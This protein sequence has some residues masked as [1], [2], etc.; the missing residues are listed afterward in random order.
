MPNIRHI[1]SS[2]LLLLIITSSAAQIQPK[3]GYLSYNSIFQAMPE[4]ATAQQKLKELKSK[5]DAEA[6]R[7]ENDFQRKFNEFLQGQKDFPENILQK[8]Q[9]EL[10][11]L[12]EEGIRFRQEA[13]EL[14]KKAEKELQADMLFILNEAIKAVGIE[15]NY[16]FIINI[17]G[18]TCPFINPAN[19]D[20]V[21]NKVREKLNLPLVSLPQQTTNQTVK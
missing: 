9:N 2:V 7:S 13:T 3:F 18:N 16:S 15:N 21:T 10:Q 4:Y 8:R 11:E 20:D 19:G 6:Q 1:L 12:Q 5:Y 14:L 17:D